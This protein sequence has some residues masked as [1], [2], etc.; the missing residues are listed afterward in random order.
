M[1]SY[2][3]E[4]KTCHH[5]VKTWN[6]FT[7]LF[8]LTE[9]VRAVLCCR[10]LWD[11]CETDGPE[12]HW[13]TAASTGN[14]YADAGGPPRESEGWKI[15]AHLPTPCSRP[16]T[17]RAI[18]STEWGWN[19]KSCLRVRTFLFKG[20]VLDKNLEIKAKFMSQFLFRKLSLSRKKPL[21]RWGKKLWHQYSVA[22]EIF[23]I[24]TVHRVIL[25]WKKFYCRQ[26]KREYEEEQKKKKT[27]EEATE[28]KEMESLIQISQVEHSRL[29]EEKT[30]EKAKLDEVRK[31]QDEILIIT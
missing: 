16:R 3:F 8:P 24:S 28:K 9:L 18:W 1:K 31:Q 6:I 20:R 12:E 25:K 30:K 26:S 2:I 29:E 13:T 21:K 27:Q 22:D 23:F 5:C 4:K 19:P 17:K 10:G 14:D 7:E 11:L 15:R